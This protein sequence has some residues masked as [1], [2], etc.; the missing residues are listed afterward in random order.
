[1]TSREQVL[2]RPVERPD[3][4]ATKHAPLRGAGVIFR[5]ELREWF[6]TRRF[7]VMTLL[8]SVMLA[9]VP[10]ILFLH[11]GGLHDGRI[12]S[13]YDG[14]L[15]SWVALSLTLG[16]YLGVA[17]SMGMLTKEEETGTAQWLFTKPVS[18]AGYVLAKYLANA[19]VVLVG[20]VLVPGIV[21]LGLA[22][23]VEASGIQDW[24]AMFET[25][26]FI[27]LN[28]LV[29]LGIVVGLSG[30]FRSN[31]PIAGIAIGMNFVP[32]FFFRIVDRKITGLFPINITAIATEAVHSHHLT[33]WEPVVSGTL[34][35]VIGVAFACLRVSRRQL[36]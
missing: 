2:D 16:S 8:T 15:E 11:E 28:S 20:A 14:L 23:V 9:C 36:Q 22:Q 3:L 35:A 13:G 5:K 30:L 25:F 19:S 24:T 27:A 26:G 18:R 4:A 33:P 34:L 31:A 6:A 32:L 1:M 29:V 7:L 12:S 10:N 21:F 17:V